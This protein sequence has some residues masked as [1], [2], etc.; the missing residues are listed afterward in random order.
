MTVLWVAIAIVEVV[1]AL[2]LIV[3]LGVRAFSKL[4]RAGVAVGEAADQWAAAAAR[5]KS[6]PLT[7]LPGPTLARGREG[8]EA[9]RNLREAVRLQR[10]TRRRARVD[11]ALTRWRDVG[12]LEH[13][14]DR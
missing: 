14:S 9:A 11:A 10:A 2:A 3:W 12:L 5:A 13:E 6:T 4:T 8:V 1:A 7:P